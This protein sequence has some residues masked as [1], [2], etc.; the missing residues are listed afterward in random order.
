MLTL[1]SFI[2]IAVILGGL[3]AAGEIWDVIGTRQDERA[4]RARIERARAKD[5]SFWAAQTGPRRSLF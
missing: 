3:T 2:V 5:D 1:I 4:E